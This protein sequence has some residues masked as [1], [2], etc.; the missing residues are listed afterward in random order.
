M[1]NLSKKEGMVYA[2][3]LS[4]LIQA[5]TVSKSGDKFFEKL[6]E[7]MAEVFPLVFKNL[8]MVRTYE[9]ALLFKWKGKSDA[10]PLVYMCH[11]DVV[12][13]N[14]STWKYPAFDGV[15]AEGKVWGRGALDC[16][17]V[18]YSEF[19]AVEE[20]LEEGFV[21]DNDVYIASGDGEEV[22][23]L[24]ATKTKEYLKAHGIKPYIVLDE[25][26]AI[27]E[28]AFKGM[29]KPYSVIGVYEKGYADVKFVARS[30]GGHSSTPPKNTPIARLSQFVA[31]IE[32]NDYFKK[33]MDEVVEEMLTAF[34][35]SLKGALKFILSNLKLFKPL[36][37]KLLPKLNS[38]GNALL[39]TT[40]AFTMSK[41]SDAA[42]VIPQEA[43]VIAN[44][45]F[46]RH[47]CGEECYKIL[48]EVAK[49]YDVDMEILNTRDAS[50]AV[51]TKGDGYKFVE[52]L[53][54]EHFPKYGVAP[55]VI[56]G[57]TDCRYYQDICENAMRF[58]PILLNAQQ[59]AAVHANDE[60]VDITAISDA[61]SF[62]KYMIIKN[63]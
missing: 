10:K 54:R 9:N 46:A 22:F 2:E 60:N 7:V 30:I 18:L 58:S 47:Q 53:V 14:E 62:Y 21:P 3:G 49:K 29:D 16:K 32:K 4:K 5:P 51:S 59:L 42:N 8:E 45:R 55:Y 33:Y 34:A 38:Y 6:R 27:I 25:A 24:G 44:L 61:V 23:G 35:P 20:L 17:G 39:S 36:V 1:E 31:D 56:M 48:G 40:I 41:G 50:P 19:Q 43:Y 26:G 11:Q 63:I 12:P 15:I 57:G 52:N 28:E 13:A 37:V